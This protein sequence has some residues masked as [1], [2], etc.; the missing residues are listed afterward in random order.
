V[1]YLARHLNQIRPNVVHLPSESEQLPNQLLA[2]QPKDVL[3]VADFRRYQKEL[4]WLAKRAKK[5]RK[6]QVLA[7]TDKWMSP[8][9]QYANEVLAIPTESGTLWDSYAATFAVL[10]ALATRIAEK[11]WD[12]TRE[13][14]EALDNYRPDIQD[15]KS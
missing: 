9:T 3:V 11:D 10:E 4:N 14:I 2:I 12:R 1:Q 6:A 5:D 15:N 8:V 13:R 7:I